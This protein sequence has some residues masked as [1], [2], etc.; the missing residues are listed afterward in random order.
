MKKINI[1][2]NYCIDL[3]QIECLKTD[4]DA[5]ARYEIINAITY[6]EPINWCSVCDH[7]EIRIGRK[8]G[9]LLL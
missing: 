8:P 9:K 7:N 3:K 2:A 5:T 1:K 6:M 4:I